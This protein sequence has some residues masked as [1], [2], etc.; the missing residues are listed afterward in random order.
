M[1]GSCG[2]ADLTVDLLLYQRSSLKTNVFVASLR[3]RFT[4]VRSQMSRNVAKVHMYQF[5]AEGLLGDKT[6]SV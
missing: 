2:P 5:K 3:S 1:M 4:A 6:C